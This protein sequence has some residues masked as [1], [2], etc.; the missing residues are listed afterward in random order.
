MAKSIRYSIHTT[1][2]SSFTQTNN[3][4]LQTNLFAGSDGAVD[5][6]WAALVI[7][8]GSGGYLDSNLVHSATFLIDG[9]PDPDTDLYQI[10][11]NYDLAYD[12]SLRIA[13]TTADPVEGVVDGIGGGGGIESVVAGSGIAIDATDPANPIVSATGGGLVDVEVTGTTQAILMG[14]S[15]RINASGDCV[16]TLPA[17]AAVGEFFEILGIDNHVWSIAQRA[18]QQIFNGDTSTT[19]GVSGT[20]STDINH[21]NIVAKCVVA[22]TT[23]TVISSIGHIIAA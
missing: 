1:A 7:E 20:L 4:T 10:S 5:A 23:F 16:L 3:D 14:R 17:T 6:A 8:D 12:M 9:H 21:G 22:N 13:G 2:T 18:G 11:P 19:V 15:Y